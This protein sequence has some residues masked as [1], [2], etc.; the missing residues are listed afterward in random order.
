MINIFISAIIQVLLMASIPFLVF[1]IKNKS[2]KGFLNY[3]GLKRST[4]TA[5]YLALLI[6]ILF[7][8]PLLLLTSTNETFKSIMTSPESTTG[9]I[10]QMGSSFESV[11]A[12][13]IIAIL[14]TSLSEEIFFRGFLAKRFIALTNFRVGNI[15]Q[16]L[17]FGCVHVLLF[18]SMTHNAL[19]LFVIF[20]FP[21]ISAYFQTYLN[22]R[23]GKG[24]II[25]G[26]IAHGIANVIAY[27]FVLFV[28]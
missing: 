1:V 2:A 23:Y 5:N 4:K 12:I 27:S 7:V 15:L 25:P 10:K 21:A 20:I 9:N 8:M 6:V 19:F 3:I 24:S 14:K 16:A 11:M 22:E 18:W 26:W 28:L 13:L 17:I